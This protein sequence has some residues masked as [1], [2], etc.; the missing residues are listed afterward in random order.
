MQSLFNTPKDT[1]KVDTTQY[2]PVEDS[3]S[4][5]PIGAVEQR[6]I[7]VKMQDEAK[8]NALKKNEALKEQALLIM[9][10]LH[11]Q[12]IDQTENI[13]KVNWGA[14]NG[15]VDRFVLGGI[16]TA[17]NIISTVGGVFGA[18]TKR[19]EFNLKAIDQAR[20]AWKEKQAVQH[21]GKAEDYWDVSGGVPEVASYMAGGISAG[22]SKAGTLTARIV[23]NIARGATADLAVASAINGHKDNAGELI[24]QEVVTGAL[25]TGVGQLLG[26]KAIIP[27]WNKML[28]AKQ[29]GEITQEQFQQGAKNIISSSDESAINAAH[30][31]LKEHYKID[32]LSTDAIVENKSFFGEVYNDL[33]GNYKKAKDLLL[34]KKSGDAIGALRHKELGEIDLVYGKE[35]TGKSDGFGLSKIAKYHPE[36]L[37][38]LDEIIYD[39]PIVSRSKNRIK[40]ES[41]DHFASVRLDWDEKSKHWLLTAF[42]KEGGN[43]N[44]TNIGKIRAETPID[45]M[46][47]SS[48]TTEKIIPQ[49]VDYEPTKLQSNPLE[50]IRYMI[51]EP[52]MGVMNGIDK[53][54]VKV[55]KALLK[56]H[57]IDEALGSMLKAKSDNSVIDG[58]KRAVVQD[59][60]LSPEYLK[61]ADN[62]QI[63]IKRGEALA[64]ELFEKLHKIDEADLSKLHNYVAGEVKEIDPKL[65]DAADFMKR[66]IKHK[67]RELVKLGL[68]PEDIMKV[69]EDGYI[70]RQ[71]T[72][73]VKRT[74]NE[75]FFS[76]SKKMQKSYKR[77]KSELFTR[78]QIEHQLTQQRVQFSANESIEDLVAKNQWIGENIRD[79][80]FT[81]E[82]YK[83]DKVMLRRDWTMAER[84]DMGEITNAAFTVPQTIVKM[85]KDIAYGKFLAE[86]A[87]DQRLSHYIKTPEEM[88]KVAGVSRVSDIPK[89][90]EFTKLSGSEF[91]KLDGL[92]VDKAVANDIKGFQQSL[93]GY[94]TEIVEGWKKLLTEWKVAKT[95]KNPT[96]HFNNFFS[97]MV[98]S[99]YA[100]IK[101][102]D[103]VKN[104]GLAISEMRTKGTFYKEAEEIGLFGRSRLNDIRAIVDKPEKKVRS[105]LGTIARNVYMAEDSKVGNAAFK[106]YSLEDDVS[107]L[108]LYMHYRKQGLDQADALKQ[109]SKV[110]FDYSKRMPSFL[111]GLRDSGVVPFISWT[112][113]ALPLMVET[114]AKRPSRYV[115]L[116][117]AYM[118]WEHAMNDGN[119]K[120]EFMRGKSLTIGNIGDRSIQV[121]TSSLTPYFDWFTEPGEA[122]K[123]LALGGIPQK[124][125]EGLTGRQFWN[126][127]KITYRDG[128]GAVGDYAKWGVN[129]LTPMP[130]YLDKVYN[131]GEAVANGGEQVRRNK[132]FYPRSTAEAGAGLF[133]LNIK[134]YSKKEQRKRE[135]EER[136]KLLRAN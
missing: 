33:K 131:V 94:D 4:T 85:Q 45:E 134:S 24:L 108:S 81:V 117:G 133:G 79:A 86:V 122:V 1:L 10:D 93:H 114:A 127:Q 66:I 125:V 5:R 107:R 113:K 40:L 98:M 129:S 76:S 57:T 19:E 73:H 60:R 23:G 110:V 88:M 128:W 44:R 39:M 91:G 89:S 132:L 121:R 111:R 61:L 120:P 11:S 46:T 72:K 8:A 49:K 100:G 17:D 31:F 65:K 112:Y 64:G 41:D 123:Q 87:T 104:T 34:S 80:R 69:Y 77:G 29:A 67:T 30:A 9:R 68:L 3:K 105:A 71:Y 102:S 99:F 136:R 103:I 92:Y 74:L 82:G 47:T 118:A 6:S 53:I 59:Y 25:F 97:N 26:E 63:T 78:A 70:N 16:E 43:A 32:D 109:S 106:L 22:M 38:D 28:D 2:A 126:D 83:N 50:A 95:V 27:L 36:V 55:Q 14:N 135:I 12:G 101:P 130:S 54:A 48:T 58:L 7:D 52:I 116:V 96:A 119:E 18:D 62:A 51:E 13:K 90:G 20:T 115:A 37:D 21:G 35:G 75:M 56:G 15:V 124:A 84:K 42:K